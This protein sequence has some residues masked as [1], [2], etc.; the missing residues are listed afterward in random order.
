MSSEFTVYIQH[1]IWMRMSALARECSHEISGL[2]K[3]RRDE[4][5]DMV[6]YDVCC[7]PQT[8]GGASTH[9]NM[10]EVAKFLTA[11]IAERKGK[12]KTQQTEWLCWWHSHP[13]GGKPTYSCTDDTTLEDLANST[14]GSTWPLFLGLVL[15][16]DGE[17]A[18][19]YIG[20]RWPCKAQLEGDVEI[21]ATDEQVAANAWAREQIK[22]KVKA[23][24]VR[25]VNT[26]A[27]KNNYGPGWRDK[28]EEKGGAQP[29]LA[30]MT[31][32]P[33]GGERYEHWHWWDGDRYH[34]DPKDQFYRP[35]PM[36]SERDRETQIATNPL[37][38]QDGRP[39]LLRFNT[40][41]MG[42]HPKLHPEEKA[43]RKML[44]TA[45]IHKGEL[46]KVDADLYTMCSACGQDAFIA[47]KDTTICLGC[48][49]DEA[50]CSCK[51]VI[52]AS[53]TYLGALAQTLE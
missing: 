19:A 15:G 21:L 17:Q 22:E 9:I 39:V 14:E 24:P 47:E 31:I 7:L 18:R 40:V 53:R 5:A 52:E 28:Q 12:K 13:G 48:E 46:F 10:E 29:P 32:G 45:G 16:G 25:V 37:R 6:V 51:E 26:R 11:D 49:R 50:Y 23:T 1:D 33:N 27:S 42:T 36:E 38:A 20:L 41:P 35:D 30:P 43:A 44:D 8:G 2:A 4:D 3:V 34:W